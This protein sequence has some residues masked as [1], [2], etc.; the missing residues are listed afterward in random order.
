MLFQH[1][2]S[3]VLSRKKTQTRRLIGATD[4]AVHAEDGSIQAV[5]VNGREKWRVGKTYAVQA[6]RGK[7]SVARIRIDSLRDES[8]RM[9]SLYDARAEGFSDREEFLTV[10][11]AI[12]GTAA[13]DRRVWVLGFTLIDA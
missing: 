12:N 13:L 6:G 11:G 10:F 9:I 2:L 8:V 5:L 4:T 7:P 3:A 1:T